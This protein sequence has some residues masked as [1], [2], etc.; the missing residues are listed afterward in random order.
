LWEEIVIKEIL[1]QE[2]QATIL[3]IQGSRIHSTEQ[4]NITKTGFRIYYSGLI[5]VAG[6][7]GEPDDLDL[8][9]KAMAM[10]KKGIPYLPEATQDQQICVIYNYDVAHGNDFIADMELLMK[11]LREEFPDFSFS[12]KIQLVDRTYKIQ[13]NA[14]LYCHYQDHFLNLK[15][16]FK[17]HSSTNSVDDLVFCFGRRFDQE[18]FLNICREKLNAFLQALDLP[19]SKTIPVIF[20]SNSRIIFSQL[21]NDLN[22]QNLASPN[23]RLHGKIASDFFHPDFTFFQSHNS[24]TLLTPFFDAEGMVNSDSEYRV[25]LIQNGMIVKGYTDKRSAME[26]GIPHTGSAV[27]EIGSLP[28]SGLANYEIEAGDQDLAHLLQ[29]QRA[30]LVDLV[31]RGSFSAQGHGEIMVQRAYLTDG[32]RLLGCL[33][34]LKLK[35]HADDMFGKDFIGV[36][37][38]P[39]TPLNQEHG[40]VMNMEVELL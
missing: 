37:K 39:L 26:L 40:V 36:S 32:I 5:G 12:K 38:D 24:E 22:G 35:T 25:P 20:P 19:T 30:V 11:A 31:S 29:G 17:H 3:H 18:V 33:P 10:L 14:G 1:S 7:C 15:L 21:I 27:S 16:N 2:E 4:K 23:S 28:E 34:A 6:A 13:N 8:E 9:K